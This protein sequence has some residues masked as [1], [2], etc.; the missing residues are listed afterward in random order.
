MD[1]DEALFRLARLILPE[2]TS[3]AE[4]GVRMVAPSLWS[5]VE[6]NRTP[7]GGTVDDDEARNSIDEVERSVDQ[8]IASTFRLY[9]EPEIAG[10]YEND[11]KEFY[12]RYERGRQLTLAQGGST[13]QRKH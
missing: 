1:K 5:L 9:R 8:I 3:S 2:A 13:E 10:L 11:P 6:R 4:D 12:R 7:E